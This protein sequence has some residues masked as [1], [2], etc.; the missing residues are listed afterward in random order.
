[1]ELT[2]RFTLN[3]GLNNCEQEVEDYLIEVPDNWHDLSPAEQEAILHDE[4]KEWA[5]NYI[6]GSYEATE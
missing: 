3:I 4:W 2:C 1:M 5:W 6:D